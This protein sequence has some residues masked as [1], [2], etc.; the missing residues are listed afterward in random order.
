[1]E[2]SKYILDSRREVV[3]TDIV[4]SLVGKW[5]NDETDPYPRAVLGGEDSS[6]GQDLYST[7]SPV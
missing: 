6:L 7:W 4:E 3:L 1:M 5:Y 2:G